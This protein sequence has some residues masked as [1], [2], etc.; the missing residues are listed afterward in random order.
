MMETVQHDE[1]WQRLHQR[2]HKI[3]KRRG[4]LDAEEA[5]C[6][7]EAYDMKLW[8]RF[9]CVHMNEYLE[10]EVGYGPQAAVERVRIARA[11]AELPQIE[12][13]L[14]EGGLPYSAVRELTRVATAETEQAWLDKVRGKNLREIEALVSGKKRGDH[15]EDPANPDLKR[16]VV[17]LEL[18]P[19]VFAL[20]RQ[21]QSAMA[22]E[23]GGQLDDSALMEILCRRALEGDGSSDRPSHQIAITVCESCG[24]GWQ[25]GAGHEIEVGHEIIDRA[26]CDAELIGSLHAEQPDRLA[27]TVT[28]RI[29]RQVFARD[30]YRCTVP[31][32]RSARNLDLH[33]IVFQRDGGS[34]ESW[35]L[36]VICSGHHQQ[37]HEGMLTV[38]GRAPHA[39]EFAWRE[40]SGRPVIAARRDAP[41]RHDSAKALHGRSRG[42][43]IATPG[44]IGSPINSADL[45]HLTEGALT[46]RRQ[47]PHVLDAASGEP[48]TSSNAAAVGDGP[49]QPEGLAIRGKGSP[50]F[51]PIRYEHPDDHV[52]PATI[53]HD[54]RAALMT[55]G[56][57]RREAQAAV[58]NAR[59]HVGADA[60]LEQVI[61]EALRH[62]AKPVVGSP[63]GRRQAAYIDSR[64]PGAWYTGTP[65]ANAGAMDPVDQRTNRPAE[66]S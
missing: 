24:R 58:E 37:L 48:S 31:G 39:L 30:H 26:R 65:S 16:R 41:Q 53:D 52:G 43:E 1:E 56:Y 15:P 60:T 45:P 59:P 61:R 46:V 12:A 7:R 19:A 66:Q 47:E 51:E 62:C 29:R 8:R 28:P 49:R 44:P 17:R 3:A 27:A 40:V 32:C 5:Q 64:Y 42:H 57:K 36:T 33:H 13:S 34:H 2:L 22:D 4:A 21:V 10:R 6:L 38:R 11:L 35:N 54:A 63:L 9:G 25:N 50:T 20:F 55:A 23:H 18:A 14:A